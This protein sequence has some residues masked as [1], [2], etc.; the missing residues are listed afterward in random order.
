MSICLDDDSASRCFIVERDLRHLACGRSGR[1]G[2]AAT[3]LAVNLVPIPLTFKRRIEQLR[4]VR[5]EYVGE[6]CFESMWN[7]GNIV[8]FL[9]ARV[10]GTVRFA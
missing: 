4:T 1:K 7:S 8:C 9:F 3:R 2:G 5:G 6:K 10:P